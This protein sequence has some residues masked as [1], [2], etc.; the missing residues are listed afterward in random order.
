MR[1]DQQRLQDILEAARRILNFAANRSK[2]D[3]E[4]DELFKSAVL[5]ELLVIGEAANHLSD[6]LK[7]RHPKISWTSLN[8]FRNRIAHE[9]FKIEPDLVWGTISNE[10]SSL[11]T[12]V[13]DIIAIEFPP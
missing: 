8:R 12:D 13:A 4:K 9:Y 6:A 10:I 5:Y 7:N 11:D 3:L 2:T 1:H